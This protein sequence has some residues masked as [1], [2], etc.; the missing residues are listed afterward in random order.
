M[1]PD[2]EYPEPEGGP[3]AQNAALPISIRINFTGSKT[4]TPADNLMFSGATGASY[5]C[6]EALGLQDCTTITGY[7]LWDLEGN[8]HVYNDAS[9]W[10]VA[11]TNENG[12]KGLYRDSNNTLQ[13]FSCTQPVHPDG[14]LPAFV[15]QPAGQQSIFYIDAPGAYWGINPSSGQCAIGNSFVD[16]GKIIFNFQATF[17]STMSSYHLTVYYYVKIA[18]SPGGT[19]DFT[20]SQAGYGNLSRLF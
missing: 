9:K 12:Y 6:S 1:V 11:V 20:N 13:P 5:T 17:T 10:T 14:P 3:Q 2:S 18:I 4:T 15:R 19:T 8:A 16:S 7:R